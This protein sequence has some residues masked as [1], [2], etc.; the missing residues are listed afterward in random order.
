ML[1]RT[2]DEIVAELRNALRFRWGVPEGL[3]YVQVW[4][5]DP[6]ELSHALVS[7]VY[8]GDPEDREDVSRALGRI[9]RDI[10]RRGWR[11]LV[12]AVHGGRV[13]YEGYAPGP[14]E[15][16]LAPPGEAPWEVLAS[17]EGRGVRFR[18]QGGRLVVTP[19][20]L[21]KDA[22]PA[23]EG[24]VPLVLSVLEDGEEVGAG[25]VLRRLRGALTATGAQA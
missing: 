7:Y 9:L 3:P 24:L 13:Y 5:I 11:V 14:G 12:F 8:H 21:A 4:G 18:R 15:R 1:V 17:L 10:R 25:E 6:E 22:F 16:F 23:V 2:L 19:A 20:E